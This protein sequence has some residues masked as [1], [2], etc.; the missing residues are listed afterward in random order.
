MRTNGWIS[1]SIRSHVRTPSAVGIG[2]ATQ[3][4]NHAIIDNS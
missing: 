4:A 1:V 2:R 3:P